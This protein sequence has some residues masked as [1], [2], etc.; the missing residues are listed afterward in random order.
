MPNKTYEIIDLW[1]AA[2]CIFGYACLESDRNKSHRHALDA[3]H[4][5]AETMREASHGLGKHDEHR[6]IRAELIKSLVKAN[7]KMFGFRVLT[8]AELPANMRR[9]TNLHV[10]ARQ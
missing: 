3:V 7:C 5:L 2:E 9:L 1:N 6:H 8:K 4:R 10:L